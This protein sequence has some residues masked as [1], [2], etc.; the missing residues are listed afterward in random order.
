MSSFIRLF[1]NIVPYFGFYWRS[2]RNTCYFPF[3]INFEWTK[4]RLTIQVHTIKQIVI[5]KWLLNYGTKSGI[6]FCSKCFPF[7][8]LL[9]ISAFYLISILF[10]AHCKFK[11]TLTF[12][13]K[14]FIWIYVTEII[15]LNT[16]F[17][18]TR[19]PFVEDSTVYLFT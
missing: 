12:N 8:F 5:G 16:A 10:S 19:N 11:D 6:I 18:M 14:K 4:W 3:E 9:E 7:H 2:V 1:L 17:R 13:K 15:Y